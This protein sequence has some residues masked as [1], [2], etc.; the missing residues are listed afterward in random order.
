MEFSLQMCR[1]YS[2]L[3]CQHLISITFDGID[4]TIMHQESI[5]MCSLPAWHCVG[6]ETGVD[7]CNGTL[8]IRTLQILEEGTKLSY[9]E[10]TFVD[11]ST[12]GT[13]YH[14]SIFDGLLKYSSC[15]IELPVKIQSLFHILRLLD[16]CLHDAW[17]L[18]QCF[19]SQHLRISGHFSP[20]KEVHAFLLHDDLKHLLCLI[21]FQFILRQEKHSNTIFS[22]SAKLNSKLFAFFGEKFVGDL[23]HDTYTVSGLSF[24]IFTCTMLQVLHDA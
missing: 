5:W 1:F 10:H 19:A 16:K 2:F 18:L 9:Q 6:G 13:G 24:C 17:H 15:N 8:I 12:A 21:A 20:A 3:T 14:I 4:L 11:Q 23:N 7:Q 22:L